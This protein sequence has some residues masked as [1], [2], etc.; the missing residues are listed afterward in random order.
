MPRNPTTGVFTRVSN[1]FSV[2]SFGTII[3]PTDADALFDDYD[4]ALTAATPSEPTQVTT[5][6]ATPPASAGALAVVRTSP[7]ATTINLPAVA[8]RDGYPLP[9]FDWS[10][11][12]AAD[13]V[14]TLVPNGAET[15]MKAAS[16]QL[17]STSVSL[18]SITLYPSTTLNGWYIA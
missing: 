2:P 13:H 5:T 7:T 11:S 3:D 9:I 8:T 15:I 17:V 18:A 16:W 12:L 1:S 14:I 10:T 4:A 6:P